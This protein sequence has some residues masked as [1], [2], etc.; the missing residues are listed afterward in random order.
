[1]LFYLS[2]ISFFHYFAI[3]TLFAFILVSTGR[4]SLLR[5]RAQTGDEEGMTH[6]YLWQAD[7]PI[8]TGLMT[9]STWS[10]SAGRP[11]LFTVSIYFFVSLS[12]WIFRHTADCHLIVLLIHVFFV[13]FYIYCSK[14]IFSLSLFSNLS[15]F[16]FDLWVSRTLHAV[17]F[18]GAFKFPLPKL[19]LIE[20]IDNMPSSPSRKNGNHRAQRFKGRP[21]R[22][23]GMH[24]LFLLKMNR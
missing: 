14:C 12:T 23:P 8:V 21:V 17:T 2:V 22:I 6:S 16:F 19:N 9:I 20:F 4:F 24:V 7:I 10:S 15:I 1:M 3:V 11:F 5:S 18:S 13:F